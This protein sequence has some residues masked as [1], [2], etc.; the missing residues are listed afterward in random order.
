M[1]TANSE[2]TP[3]AT[4]D[5]GVALVLRNAPT[6]GAHP[7]DNP[8]ILITQRRVGTPYAAYWEFPGGKAEPGESPEAC[9]R[10]E[11]REELGVEVEISTVFPPLIH[12]YDHATVRIFPALCRLARASA[13]PRALEV[14]AWEWRALLEL[15]WEAFL[16]ANVRIVTALMRHLRGDSP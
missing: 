15:P 11:L 1:K 3:N 8:Q 16:P 12:S 14:A 4:V 7:P 9:V 2:Q 13:E 6:S 10:R 5:V